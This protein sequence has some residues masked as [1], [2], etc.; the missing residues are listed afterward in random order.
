MS[1]M[2]RRIILL[3]AAVISFLAV[4]FAWRMASRPGSHE[5][6][7]ATYVGGEA[8]AA[9]HAREHELWIG[10]HHD[11][12]MQLADEASVL[13]DFD[14]ATF[15]YYGVQSTFFERDGVFSVRTDG[16]DGKL[17]D[18][19]IAY[20]FGVYPLQQYLIGFPGGRYQ[21]LGI[22]WDS[23]PAAAGGQRWFHL[24]PDV[25]I[26]S[27]DELHWT[28]SNQTWNFMC[29]ACHSTNLQK[30]YDLETD[31]Y[32]TTWSEINV[33]CE[34]CHG[35]GS[36]HVEWAAG[37]ADLD[38]GLIVH[39]TPGGEWSLEAATG[40]ARLSSPRGSHAQIETCAPCHSR[41]SAV[42]ERQTQG[43]LLLQN[44]RLA[45]LTEGMYYADGQI[46]DEVYVYG[47]FLQGKMY[48]AGVTC[49]DCH[50]PHSLR[51]RAAGNA[52]CTRCHL[53]TRFDT[54]THHFHS[55]GSTGAACVSCHMPT[56]TNLC[57]SK[58]KYMVLI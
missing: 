15:T 24:Y 5:A 51:T 17:H 31:S 21:P 7:E 35:P 19:E 26:E 34:A 52:L 6:A 50:D 42:D 56:R 30:N 33:S 16:P 32:N 55:E 27:G 11:L 53:S 23:R 38:N 39:L 22:A 18:Y 54:P 1:P 25:P 44:Y 43:H 49:S 58:S 20:T 37:G 10:S 57:I 41:R 48:H 3:L 36:T 8:C 14:D 28:A 29:A 2:V 40:T 4:L 46:E 45:L 9:C 47:S 13:G 12:A